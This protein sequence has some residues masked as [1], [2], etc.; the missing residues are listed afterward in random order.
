[1]K[2]KCQ[3]VEMCVRLLH[4]LTLTSKVVYEFVTDAETE[5]IIRQFYYKQS[6]RCNL[7]E[8]KSGKSEQIGIFAGRFLIPCFDAQTHRMDN[9]S[10]EVDMDDGYE[11]NI[12]S[13]E[14]C[15]NCL[16]RN[17]QLK[18]LFR[19]DIIDGEIYQLPKVYQIVTN[20]TVSENRK[21]QIC[22]T[23]ILNF[24]HMHT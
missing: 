20:I 19:F 8:K 7:R 14:I 15:R 17:C 11:L 3:N 4:P 24:R 2:L 10:I 13:D 6:K 21:M 18:S 1:M 5:S 23:A 9:I 16:A 22:S 12:N